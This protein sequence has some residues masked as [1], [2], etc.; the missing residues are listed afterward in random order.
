L[1]LI[2]G[3]VNA[4]PGKNPHAGKELAER[5]SEAAKGIENL[6]VDHPVAAAAFVFE[7]E[8]KA[9]QELTD[10]GNATN[11]DA[12]AREEAM[13]DRRAIVRRI[14]GLKE[15]VRDHAIALAD[16]VLAPEPPR[17]LSKSGGADV[18]APIYRGLEPRKD[19]KPRT[20]REAIREMERKQRK[21]GID[22]STVHAVNEDSLARLRS[23]QLAEWVQV[24]GEGI[25]FNSA[26]AKHPVTA[27]GSK[28]EGAGSFKLFKSDAGEII[29]AVVA[30]TSGNYKPGA[31]ATEAVVQSL[32]ASGVR[33][34]RIIVTTAAPADTAS[35][36]LLMRAEAYEPRRIKAEIADLIKSVKREAKQRNRLSAATLRARK[37]KGKGKKRPTGKSARI[38]KTSGARKSPPKRVSKSTP[39]RG[40]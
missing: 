9:L 34:S 31:G 15:R 19:G 11:L 5:F 4:S 32:I 20:S 23:G 30:P 13:G 33:E 29:L 36:K 14:L 40:R 39:R 26:E 3:S 12:L 38:A 37:V 17:K 24:V 1:L 7:L 27:R 8:I 2:P 25:T 22:T 21:K 28:V 10:V 18:Y 16:K 6:L 35:V